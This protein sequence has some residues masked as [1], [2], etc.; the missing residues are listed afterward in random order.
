MAPY[1][2]TLE[3]WIIKRRCHIYK[4]W[5]R[6]GMAW[7]II[8]VLYVSN[9]WFQVITTMPSEAVLHYI[10]SPLSCMPL[11]GVV[12][13]EWTWMRAGQAGQ[14]V[15]LKYLRELQLNILCVD[16]LIVVDNWLVSEWEKRPSNYAPYHYQLFSSLFA[17]LTRLSIGIWSFHICA[18][19]ML[20]TTNHNLQKLYKW[21]SLPLGVWKRLNSFMCRIKSH[22]STFGQ[23]AIQIHQ[24]ERV[25]TVLSVTAYVHDSAYVCD[26][27]LYTVG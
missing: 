27:Y 6:V 1:H 14:A 23:C 24:T 17:L 3:G 8:M 21:T 18:L 9:Y 2:Y 22:R 16:H 15:G 19:I 10:L 25:G 7:F 20:R 4:L 12:H 13:E 26:L 5:L 11:T